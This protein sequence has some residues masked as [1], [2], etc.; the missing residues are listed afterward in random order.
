LLPN[1]AFKG[2]DPHSENYA[3]P[4]N[5]EE[6]QQLLV[7]GTEVNSQLLLSL[8]N[9]QITLLKQRAKPKDRAVFLVDQARIQRGH[10]SYCP[11]QKSQN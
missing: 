9:G 1:T 7:S 4:A 6:N 2:V 10:T 3:S 11:I 8:G 5:A